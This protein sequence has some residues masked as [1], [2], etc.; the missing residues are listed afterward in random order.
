MS[1][2]SRGG[3]AALTFAAGFVAA[4]AFAWLFDLLSRS[5]NPD[6]CLH[7]TIYL[8]LPPLLLG[9]GGIALTAWGVRRGGALAGFG[10]GMVTASVYPVLYLSLRAIGELRGIGCAG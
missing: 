7:R 5:L 8:L 1:A 2:P 4:V 9:P 6:P 3:Q 10:I